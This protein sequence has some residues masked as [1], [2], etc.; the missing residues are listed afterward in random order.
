MRSRLSFDSAHASP[1]PSAWM[2]MAVSAIGVHSANTAIVVS[3][4]NG[5]KQSSMLAS[6][7]R[8][9]ARHLQLVLS[10]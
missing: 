6:G 2:A 8:T 4:V 9:S 7:R 1:D 3:A 5:R 10:A